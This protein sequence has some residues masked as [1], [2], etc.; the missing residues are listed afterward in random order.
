MVKPFPFYL[1]KASISAKP[2][3]R[4]SLYL[5]KASISAKP[6]S[7]QSLYL[8][9]ASISAKPLSQQSLYLSKASISAKPFFTFLPFYFFTFKT[10]FSYCSFI[11][12]SAHE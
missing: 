9:K 11:I 6:I 2:L 8:S 1:S 10:P 12:P 5:S 7:Q 3:S 4:R